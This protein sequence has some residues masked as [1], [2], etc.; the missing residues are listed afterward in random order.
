VG[1][2]VSHL[3]DEYVK[4]S[5]FVERIVGLNMFTIFSFWNK[6]FYIYIYQDNILRLCLY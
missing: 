6:Q 5:L 3:V 2:N 1:N 4:P